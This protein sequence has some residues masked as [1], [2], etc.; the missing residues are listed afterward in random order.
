MVSKV[1]GIKIYPK[2]SLGCILSASF[3][4]FVGFMLLLGLN[5]FPIFGATINGTDMQLSA[6][7]YLSY[8]FNGDI[9]YLMD[10]LEPLA[11]VTHI[12]GGNKYN[13]KLL[14]YFKDFIGC[15]HNCGNYAVFWYGEPVVAE[16]FD[17]A[18]AISYALILPFAL[19]M[20]IEGIIRLATG[21]YHKTAKPF[22]IICLILMI[23][24]VV[25]SFFTNFCLKYLAKEAMAE[26]ET[27]VAHA[28]P[29]K[30]VLFVICVL[31]VVGQTMV[32]SMFIKDK[33]YVSNGRLIRKS[34]NKDVEEEPKKKRKGKEVKPVE[35][36]VVEEPTSIEESVAVEEPAVEETPVVEAPAEEVVENA[37]KEEIPTDKGP[38]EQKSE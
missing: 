19:A 27:Y 34:K 9:P 18:I 25:A 21:T 17:Y 12:F 35:E 13:L 38:N 11:R 6:F 36:V 37:V 29:M 8:A 32:F 16:A 4:V 23:I 33:L 2:H 7:D 24:L 20:F 22:T 14:D 28:C 30:Y 1:N 31:G 26:G 3:G 5:F 15:A 10:T